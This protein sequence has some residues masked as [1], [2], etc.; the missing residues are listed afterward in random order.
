MG[1]Y[2]QSVKMVLFQFILF[3]VGTATA[4]LVTFAGNKHKTASELWDI[5]DQYGRR[6]FIDTSTDFVTRY[7]I[8]SQVFSLPIPW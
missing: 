6:N 1:G 8:L 5:A 7:T 3:F 2:T 4:V